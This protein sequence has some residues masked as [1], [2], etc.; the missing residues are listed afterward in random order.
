MRN[1]VES[2]QQAYNTYYSG[3]SKEHLSSH[4]FLKNQTLLD[5][6]RNNPTNKTS[7]VNYGSKERFTKARKNI[8]SPLSDK[9]KSNKEI[10]HSVLNEKTGLY[11]TNLNT[12]DVFELLMND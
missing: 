2:S 1:D 12:F 8:N 9:R 10:S 3:R 5:Y 7:G 11:T 6:A 4:Q